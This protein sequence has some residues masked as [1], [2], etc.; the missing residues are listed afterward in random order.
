MAKM[1][2]HI[3]VKTSDDEFFTRS[4][5]GAIWGRLYFELRDEAFPD[6]GWT[7]LVAGFAAAWLDALI[8]IAGGSKTQ[9]RVWFMDGPF[10]V[11]VLANNAHDLL[12]VTFLHKE[13]V[14]QSAEANVR[15]LLENAI[16]VSEEVLVSCKKRGWADTDVSNLEKAVQRGVEVLRGLTG[17]S[18]LHP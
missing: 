15:E 18:S 9:E 1:M 17:P 3:Q 7:D 6:R 12:K 2:Q 13:A 11:E 5:S 14:K 8:R 16:S 10:A 4:Q